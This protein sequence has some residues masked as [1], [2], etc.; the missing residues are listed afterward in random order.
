VLESGGGWRQ[1][2]TSLWIWEAWQTIRPTFILL[3]GD[4]VLFLLLMGIL[5]LGHYV[6]EWVP[7]SQERRASLENI[8]FYVVTGAWVFFS[9]VLFVELGVAFLKRMQDHFKH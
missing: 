2:L 9:G 5:A 4:S 1:F 3:V 8:H 7:A 6:I